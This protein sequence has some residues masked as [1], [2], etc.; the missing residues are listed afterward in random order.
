MTL[1]LLISIAVLVVLVVV[2]FFNYNNKEIALRKEAEAQRGK[3]E[4]VHDKMFKI[5]QEKANVATEY[6]HAFEKIYPEI[7]T[8]RYSNG[9]KEM[10]K[11]IQEHNPNFDTALYADLMQ[12]IEVQ[13]E[14]F[15][16]AQTRMLDIINMREALIEQYPSRW[17]IR[18]KDGIEYTVISSTHTQN[19]MQSGTD[20]DI[21]NFK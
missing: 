2:S 6:R 4:A 13:R 1:I 5:I 15:S 7:I 10:M 12:S 21:L 14:A 3:I 20:N 16:T 11:W 9:N 8:G 18:N 17:F 19:V